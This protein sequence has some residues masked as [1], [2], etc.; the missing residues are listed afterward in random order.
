MAVRAGVCVDCHIGAP[1][2]DGMPARN[3]DHDMIAAG[4]P[5]LTFEMSAFLANMPHHWDDRAEKSRD[6]YSAH[7][8]AVGQVAST[9]AALRLL[10]ARA[11]AAEAAPRNGPLAGAFRIR[12]LHLPSWIVDGQL[13]AEDQ[14]AGRA[15]G[16]SAVTCGE[17]GICR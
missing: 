16:N 9:Q 11:K 15:G 8:W 6:D 2:A 5:R 7:V 1:G 17:L 13:S 12:L 3:M 14:E 4:H 10:A